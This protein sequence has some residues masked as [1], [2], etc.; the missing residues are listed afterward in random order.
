MTITRIGIATFAAAAALSA[1]A[2][3]QTAPKVDPAKVDA[4][5]AA[6]F[7]GASPEWKKRIEQDDTQRLCSQY[8]AG[9]VPEKE[10]E[11]TAARERAKIVLPA[12]GKLLGDWKAGEKIAQTGTG[13]QFSDGPNTAKGGNCYACHQLSRS[14]LSYGTLGPSLIEYGKSRSFGAEEAKAAYSKIYDPHAVL[15]CSE[16]PRFGAS[17]FLSEQQ[18]KDLVA[19]LFDPESPVNK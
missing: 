16:M 2:M 9:D 15:P 3:A 7:K 4:V 1:I 17:G 11:A 12:D 18:I 19:L 8:R 14:E 5:V 6:T 13:G 10:R